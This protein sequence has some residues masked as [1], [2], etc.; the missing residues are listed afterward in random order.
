[1]S[2]PPRT[3]A[4]LDVLKSIDQSLRTLVVIAQKKAEARV[5]MAASKPGP[6]VASDSDLDGQYGDPEIKA[7]DPRE[8]TG[9]PMQCRRFSECPAEYLEMVA[10][11][12]D[13]FVSQNPQATDEDKKKAKYD[14]LDA[15]RARGWAKRIREGTHVPA[16]AP[17]TATDWESDPDVG[18]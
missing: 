1:M 5:T 3:G 9:E 18:F 15:A 12:K 4:T 7:K 10:D 2:E 11:R 13:Y 17:D 8:W 16:K 6:A 14:R